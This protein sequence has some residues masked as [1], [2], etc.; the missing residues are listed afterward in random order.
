MY[1]VFF[2]GFGMGGSLIVAIGAQNAFVLSQGVRRNHHL[3]VAL[4]CTLCDVILISVGISGVGTAVASN[5]QLG[6]IAA[7]G[8]AAFLF[9]YGF[10]ALRSAMKGQSLQTDDHAPDSLRA[11][12]ALTLGVTLLNPHV[13]LDT[14]VLMG[15]IS[16]QYP[17]TART[18]FGLGAM[19][20]SLAWF[21]LLALGGQALAPV[22]RRPATWRMLDGAVCATMWFLGTRLILSTLA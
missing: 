3:A 10:G 8:G 12:L 11:V 7:F 4:L 13:Y 5:P 14:V 17:A 18:L 21:L 1:S 6:Q 20:A 22:F 16:G 15:S 9:W 2:E 19:S